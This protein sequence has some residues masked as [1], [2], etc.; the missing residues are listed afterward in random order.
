MFEALR[1]FHF[2][3]FNKL[4]RGGEPRGFEDATND[5]RRNQRRMQLNLISLVKSLLDEQSSCLDCLA[6]GERASEKKRFV[7]GEFKFPLRE[8]PFVYSKWS[9][10]GFCAQPSYGF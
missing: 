2:R 1:D 5:E 10:N 9:H 7:C 4:R 3:F 6:K 8:L